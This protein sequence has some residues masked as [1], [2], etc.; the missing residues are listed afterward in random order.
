MLQSWAD[1]LAI[2]HANNPYLKSVRLSDWTPR[3]RTIG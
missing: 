2:L 1:I 3:Y